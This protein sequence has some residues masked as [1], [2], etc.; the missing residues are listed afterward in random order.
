MSHMNG[1]TTPDNMVKRTGADHNST[2]ITTRNFTQAQVHFL[3]NVHVH[4][5]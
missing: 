2:T 1:T 4:L 5:Q 3:T